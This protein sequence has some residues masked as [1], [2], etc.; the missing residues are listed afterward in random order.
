LLDNAIKYAPQ[1]DI[2]IDAF[3]EEEMVCIQVK[4][5]GPGIPEDAIP[6]IFD[7][8]YRVNMTDSQTVYGHGL[9]L[10]MVKRFVET[11]NGKIRAEQNQPNGSVFSVYLPMIK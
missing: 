6:F 5:F 3:P 9:G 4:D 2:L 11:L 7:R 8:F 1:G 10:Y